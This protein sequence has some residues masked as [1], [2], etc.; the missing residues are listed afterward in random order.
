MANIDL[1]KMSFHQQKELLKLLEQEENLGQTGGH[2]DK[3]FPDTG[4]CAY[5]LYAKH[6]DFFALGSDWRERCFMSANRVGKT[7]AGAYEVT[8]HLTGMYPHWWTG[9]RFNHPVEIWVAG[10]TNQTT[11]D[12]LQKCLLGDVKGTGMI[13]LDL[14]GK[15]VNKSGVSGAYESVR[16]KHAA[17]G[18]STLGFKTYGEGRKSFQGTGKHVIWLD[19]ECPDDVYNEALIRT[20]TT[21][22]IIIVT[23]TPLSGLTA[24]IQGFLAEANKD[25][26]ETKARKAVV[27]AGWDDVP[28]LSDEVKEEL[29]AS[30]PPYLRDSRSK[31]TPGLGAGAIYPI[32][33]EEILISPFKL[34]PWFR[35]FYGFDVGW[36]W[37]AAVF[38]AWDHD[39]DIVYIYDVYKKAAAEPFVHAGAIRKR[40]IGKVVIPGAIDPGARGRSQIDGRKLIQL[41]RAEGLYIVEADNAVSAGIDTVWDRLSS[42]RL[43][44]FRDLSPWLEEYR[45]YRRNEKGKIIKEKDHA[46][47]ATRYGI[48]TGIKIA[49]PVTI[50]PM[51]NVGGRRYF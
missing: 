9:K 47:D 37:T 50:T 26:A 40:N 15:T 19:E 22:G 33:E 38:M 12:I 30:T 42:G 45:I 29:I 6:M 17:G 43:K 11:K 44:V 5:P 41:Y 21:G 24:F 7:I 23:F 31:G 48:M 49:K 10:D 2:L 3:F 13:A 20:M 25:A 16:V 34:P 4:E 36:N 18:W 28:H 35:R 1:D 14:I 39:R 27:T 8:C 51:K 46:M 32:P